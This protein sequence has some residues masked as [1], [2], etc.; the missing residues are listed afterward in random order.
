[1]AS[2]GAEPAQQGVASALA[3][4]CRQIGG[5]LGL[6]AL[7][8]VANAHAGHHPGPHALVGG[9]RTAG[10]AAATGTLGG[11]FIGL[12]LKKQ[13]RPAP[14]PATAPAPAPEATDAA[15]QAG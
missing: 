13:S 4:T 10:W 15:A 9:L 14:T 8:A 2:S 5:A 12:G 7:V 1:M 6:A 11:A 3:S